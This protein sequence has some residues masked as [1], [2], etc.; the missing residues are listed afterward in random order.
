MLLPAL[1][2]LLGLIG[3][4]WSADRFISGAAATAHNLGMAPMLIGLTIVSLG[5]SAPE[6]M[7]SASAA[8]RGAGEIAIGNAIGSNLANVG[9][10]LGITALIAPILVAGSL[11]RKELPIVVLATVGAGALLLDS[12]LDRVDGVSM[13]V[14]LLVVMVL[15][16]RTDQAAVAAREESGEDFEIPEMAMAPAL[17]WMI[18]GLLLLIASAEILVWGAVQLALAMGVSPI[19]IG[20]TVIAVGTSLPELAASGISAWKGYH[21]IAIGNILGSNMFNLLGVTSVAVL[22]QPLQLEP[23]V[24][25]R[26]YAAMTAI[27]LLLAAVI[28]LSHRRQQRRGQR[29]YIGRRA[30][31]LLLF[32]YAGYYY[33]LFPEWG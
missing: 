21:D 9:M 25:Y 23:T 27:T 22:I 28:A 8:M 1:A 13:L 4:L 19:I 31:A 3:L 5:T 6:L 16:F 32:C 12:T 18:L 26:D 11:P 17:A 10:V 20:L 33:L 2:L 14:A 29:A 30:G 15:F 7:V 24:L